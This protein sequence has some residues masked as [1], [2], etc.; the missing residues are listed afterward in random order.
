MGLHFGFSHSD[1]CFFDFMFKIA[2]C[3]GCFPAN[4]LKMPLLGQFL[5]APHYAALLPLKVLH[6]KSVT[7]TAL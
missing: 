3:L 1:Y 5:H 4:C 6:A 2:L 7:Q